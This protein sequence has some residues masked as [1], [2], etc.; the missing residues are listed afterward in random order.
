M[1]L[2]QSKI[3]MTTLKH[4]LQFTDLYADG[5]ARHLHCAPLINTKHKAD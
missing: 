2:K 4:Y 3:V 5:D 1:K